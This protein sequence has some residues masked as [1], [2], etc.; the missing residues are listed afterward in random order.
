MIKDWSPKWFISKD[1]NWDWTNKTTL[2]HCLI[3]IY[4]FCTSSFFLIFFFPFS[5]P[6]FPFYLYSSSTLISSLNKILLSIRK[7]LTRHNITQIISNRT[8]FN[9]LNSIR[10][11][12]CWINYIHCFNHWIIFWINFHIEIYEINFITHTLI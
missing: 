3:L 10:I 8:G 2:N 6:V 5:L 1:K 12:L 4:I 11:C 9:F 7:S